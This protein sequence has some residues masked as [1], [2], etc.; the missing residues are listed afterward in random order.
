METVQIHELARAA[1]DDILGH[2]TTVARAYIEQI[3]GM[4]DQADFLSAL[5]DEIKQASWDADRNMSKQLSDISRE[6]TRGMY[7]CAS[8]G[9][10]SPKE[11]WKKTSRK[12]TTTE[13]TYTDAG[14]GDDDMFGEVTRLNTYRA[15]PICGAEEKIDS[16][17]LHTENERRRR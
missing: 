6:L 14:Y 15:C 12:E 4:D 2:A 11:E 16:M 13:C 17:W 8:C 10:H 7:R 9:K 5:N 1:T 3:D